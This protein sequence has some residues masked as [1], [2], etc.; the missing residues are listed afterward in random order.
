M[1]AMEG[2]EAIKSFG[3]YSDVNAAA[4]ITDS[5]S[6]IAED[7]RF[8]KLPEPVSESPLE[9]AGQL[10]V[11]NAVS[12]VLTSCA[13]TLLAPG[14]DIASFARKLI[15]EQVHRHSRLCC[16]TRT[17]TI[18]FERHQSAIGQLQVA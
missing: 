12:E 17:S 10:P 16:T 7:L 2:I 15:V 4:S 13:T 1:E 14:L 5:D 11:S 8:E 18:I 9:A 3:A 6:D